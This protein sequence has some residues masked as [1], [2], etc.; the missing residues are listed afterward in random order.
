MGILT[1]PKTINDFPAVFKGLIYG[2]GGTKKTTF[3]STFPNP[4]WLDFERSTDVLRA[5]GKT[6]IP[7]VRPKNM[8]E[9]I[10]AAKEFKKS[11]YE[12]LVLD[13]ATRFQ[14]FQLSEHMR[15]V[16]RQ[17]PSRDVY[18][19]YQADYRR[20]GNIL[21]ELFVT[22]HDTDKHVVIIAHEKVFVDE[23]NGRVVAI[24]PDLTPRLRDAVGGLVSVVG[25]SELKPG[26]GKDAIPK[27]TIHFTSFGK[28]FAKN[29]LG[30]LTP[31]E[32]PTFQN[33]FTER[34]T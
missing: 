3:A 22:L 31:I 12:T 30:I 29:R 16:H 21:D 32:E 24:L 13:T 9:V 7:V 25:Y 26:I 6:N 15:D 11:P 27:H 10:E 1:N 20:S 17:T 23:E 28:V 19:P 8:A 2:K 33:V 14:L 18:L 5:L 4:I 34:L